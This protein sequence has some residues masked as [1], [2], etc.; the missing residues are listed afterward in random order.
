V[1]LK[2]K[3]M[4]VT[5]AGQG[6]GRAIAIRFAREGALQVIVDINPETL[7]ETGQL[8]KEM[9]ASYVPVLGDVSRPEDAGKIVSSA[10]E[11]YGGIDGLI[12]NAAVGYLEK[13][14]HP[15]LETSEEDWDRQ[16]DVNLKSIY[17]VS[18][19][20]LP[21]MMKRSRGKIVNIASIA[22]VQA[23]PWSAAYCAAKAGVVNLTRSMALDYGKHGIHVNAIAPG[24]IA[25]PMSQYKLEMPE[26]KDFLI[27]AIPLGRFGSPDDIAGPAVFLSS[28]DSDFITGHVLLVDG[29][30]SIW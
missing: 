12:N 28:S 9:E 5:G 22:G 14:P 24:T 13:R 21:E 17:L 2:N 18:R 16:I 27:K 19:A 25:T 11:R 29:G 26:V 20:V 10:I 8:L 7:K 3:V 15:L 30:R 1:K 23:I 4:I 6:I